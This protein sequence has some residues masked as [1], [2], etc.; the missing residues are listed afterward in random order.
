MNRPA[1]ASPSC[2]T[3]PIRRCKPPAIEAAG[4]LQDKEALPD[5]SRCL[6][7]CARRGVPTRALEAIAMLPVPQSP[8]VYAVSAD[9]DEKMRAAAAEA[10][11]RLGIRPIC[12][13]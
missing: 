11:A 7:P 5:S 6:Q 2:C 12:R 4:V 1:R 9:K 13:L 3:I 8:A 10:F